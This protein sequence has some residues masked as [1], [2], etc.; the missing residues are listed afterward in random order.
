MRILG[1]G[2]FGGKPSDLVWFGFETALVFV[3]VVVFV[4]VV[5]G[6]EYVSLRLYLLRSQ[7]TGQPSLFRKE[8]NRILKELNLTSRDGGT[9]EHKYR[10]DKCVPRGPHE[11]IHKE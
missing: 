5:W 7:G 9:V 10:M 11:M 6:V 1:L 4:C 8:K 2:P 3:F